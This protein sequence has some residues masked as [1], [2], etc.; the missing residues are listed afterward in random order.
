MCNRWMC[1]RWRKNNL[2]NLRGSLSKRGHRPQRTCLGCGVRE[3]QNKLIRLRV[4]EQGELKIG[5]L[6]NGRGGYLH[7]A[8]ACWRAFL[9]KKSLHRAFRVEVG[10]DVREKLVRELGEQYGE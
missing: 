6:T 10:R 7:S 3:E 2:R 4:G 8:P 1:N 9:R 5:G